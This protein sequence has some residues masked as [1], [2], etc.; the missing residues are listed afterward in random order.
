[1][2]GVPARRRRSRG[3]I[4]AI[5]VVAVIAALLV[6]LELA[7]RAIVPQVVRSQIV[8]NLG[9]PEDQAIDVDVPGV[10]LPQLAVG[11]IAEM[12][13]RADDVEIEGI[14]GDAR[15][16]IQ[17]APVWGGGDWS[18]A[19]AVVVL[20]EEQLRTLLGRVDDFPVDA[21]SLDAP[22]VALDTELSLFGASVPLGVHLAA[23]AED[24]E[25]VLSPTTFRLGGVDVSADALR[26]QV[27]PLVGSF[28]ES[29]PVC[30]AEYLPSALT[31]TDVAV[32]DRGV[33]ASFDIDS[34]ILSDEKAQQP[35][36]CGDA[37]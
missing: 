30:L 22:E 5:I 21:V 26:Q 12:S 9:L 36:T 37:S 11:S 1:M 27:G 25:L 23:T 2:T 20:D 4:A 17:D 10:L 18:G 31:L 35:G 13:L 24:G 7:A 3:W 28:A 8:A 33:V 32:E 14:S 6:A 34:A 16:D 19:R 29:W 15:V